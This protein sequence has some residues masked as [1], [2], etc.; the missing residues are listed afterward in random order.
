[1]LDVKPG[2]ERATGVVERVFI[3]T[4]C[5]KIFRVANNVESLYCPK[6]K[7]EDVKEVKLS[8]E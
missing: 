2:I 6:C 1:M 5:E 3:C 8:A 7:S 4:K